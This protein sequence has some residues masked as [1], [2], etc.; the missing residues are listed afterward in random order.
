MFSFTLQIYVFKK[1]KSLVF[2]F[3]FFNLT[4]QVEVLTEG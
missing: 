4:E 3:F 1:S 2:F